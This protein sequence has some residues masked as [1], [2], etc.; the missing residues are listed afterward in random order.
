MPEHGLEC[1]TTQWKRNWPIVRRPSGCCT[2]QAVCVFR[3]IAA[4]DSGAVLPPIPDEY[5]H[6]PERGSGSA[7]IVNHN[8]YRTAFS[9]HGE[10]D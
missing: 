10:A 9:F 4:S 5:C 2:G 3:S 7:A 6:P 1:Q 8:R